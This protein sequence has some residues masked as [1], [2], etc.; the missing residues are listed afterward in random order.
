MYIYQIYKKKHVW[1]KIGAGRGLEKF[2]KINNVVTML[3]DLKDFCC[4]DLEYSVM[5]C[6]HCIF[7]K[8]V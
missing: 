6:L 5:F 2:C 3:N 4:L 7:T 8:Y 1:N